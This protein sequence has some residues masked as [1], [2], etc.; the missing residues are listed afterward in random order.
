MF[1][2][3]ETIVPGCAVLTPVV[4]EDP[5]GRFVKIFHDSAFR[6]FGLDG[7]FREQYYTTSEAGVLRG[8]HF[9]LPPSDHAKLICCLAGEIVD[10]ALDLRR[11]SPSYLKHVA[12]ELNANEGRL[13]FIPSGLAHGFYVTKGPATVLYNATSVHDPERD[14]GI[15]WDSAGISWPSD[16]PK[17]SERD[18]KLPLLE[19]FM[20][21]FTFDP[22]NPAGPTG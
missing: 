19:D 6:S 2:R 4:H 13:M 16:A 15:R 17:L 12:E 18:G 7:R 22:R 8:L 3:R 20:S 1:E 10:V 21:P 9:Q 5:R 11:G 14:T